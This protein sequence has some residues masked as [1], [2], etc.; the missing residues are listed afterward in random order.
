LYGTT[1]TMIP[2]FNRSPKDN[3]TQ[4]SVGYSHRAR[5]IAFGGVPSDLV[6]PGTSGEL[7]IDATT[8][9]IFAGYLG[10]PEVTAKKIRDG[11]Y[12]TGD[13]CVRNADGTFALVGR[14]DDAIRSGAETVYP[15]EVEAVL[16]EHPGV[17]E[18]CV[19]GLPDDYWGEIVVACIVESRSGLAWESLD[20]HCRGSRLAAFKRPRAYIFVKAI[21]RNAANK[22]VR[23][24]V[25]ETAVVAVTTT[26]DIHR[27]AA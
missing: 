18:A 21:P 23:S 5:V 16:A 24:L 25:R 10:L 19:I 20:T 26:N 11:W 7:I 4:F 6:A 15:E 3:P 17:R 13:V 12:Y 1:E 22:I 2:F 27:V 14:V 9:S 8:D